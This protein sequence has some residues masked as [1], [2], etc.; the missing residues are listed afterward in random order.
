[1]STVSGVTDTS[2]L[3]QTAE[4]KET[5]MGKDDF[6]TLLVAQL[7]NQDPLNPADATEFTSQLAQFSQLEQ[8]SNMNTKLESFAGMADQVERQSALGLMGEEVVVQTS[9]FETDGGPQTL[10]Y[11]IE[12]PADKV[13]LYVLDS[14]G[15]NVATLTGSGTS[16]GEYF[17]DW[18]GNSDAGQPAG[19]GTYTLVVRALDEDEKVL[20][21][22]SLVRGTVSGVEL[23]ANDTSLTTTAGTFSM[24]K[25][26]KVGA[27]H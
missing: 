10:G 8:L 24:A 13:N 3:F 21:S 7:E 19:P 12:V 2:S 14:Q 18:D 17:V 6:L 1:M 11:R 16:P 26:E 23:G 15:N 9:Q 27:V 4:T 20:A 22:T 25:V 5:S